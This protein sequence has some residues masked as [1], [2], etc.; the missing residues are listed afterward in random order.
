MLNNSAFPQDVENVLEE[1]L[2]APEEWRR[3]LSRERSR[4]RAY[5]IRS[6]QEVAESLVQLIVRL[7][8]VPHRSTS[9]YFSCSCACA[10]LDGWQFDYGMR[11]HVVVTMEDSKTVGAYLRICHL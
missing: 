1:E 11:A 5:Y 8:L 3:E 7:N 10:C 2:R 6:S 9:D 4:L